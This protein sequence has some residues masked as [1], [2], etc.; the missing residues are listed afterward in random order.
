MSLF[1]ALIAKSF[2]I[3]LCEYTDYSGNFQQISRMLLRKIQKN[4]KLTVNYDKYKFVIDCNSNECVTGATEALLMCTSNSLKLNDK[5]IYK[6]SSEDKKYK[7]ESKYPYIIITNDNIII[8]TLNKLYILDSNGNILLSI[9]NIN[10]EYKNIRQL[11]NSLNFALFIASVP[12]SS[13]IS[14][15]TSKIFSYSSLSASV[16][17]NLNL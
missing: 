7:E 8:Q 17:L 3:V 12:K 6:D 4:T 11:N 1:Y 14:K 5:V 9:N 16:L 15:S 13:R 2:D 10:E